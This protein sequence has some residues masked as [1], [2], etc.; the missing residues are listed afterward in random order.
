MFV[1]PLKAVYNAVTDVGSDGSIQPDGE[2]DELRILWLWPERALRR[3]HA[4]SS[5]LFVSLCWAGLLKQ[6]NWCS[7]NSSDS[8]GVLD[9]CSIIRCTK[10]LIK[11][12]N[13][14]AYSLIFM[15][16]PV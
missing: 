2:D 9:E 13:A 7:L 16:V 4:A 8:W 10:D 15:F 1:C 3:L 5:G 11:E 14:A 6:L 12:E